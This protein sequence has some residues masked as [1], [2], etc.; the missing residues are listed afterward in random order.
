MDSVNYRA[1]D[2]QHFGHVA[3][4]SCAGAFARHF[5]Y[6]T[7]EIDVNEVRFRLFNDKRCI[8]HSFG[9]TAVDLYRN[10]PLRIR[11]GQFACG[12]GDVANERVGIDELGIDAI[13]AVTLAQR[14]EG[15]IGHV[16]HGSE[17]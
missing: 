11:D 10:R 12:R 17:I 16:L 7:T 5:L 14:T 1:G 4:Q 2:F 3:E 6:R 8:A 9:L 13:R 15:G